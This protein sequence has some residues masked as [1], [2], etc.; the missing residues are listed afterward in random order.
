MV[1]SELKSTPKKPIWLMVNK[2][3][4]NA[5]GFHYHLRSHSHKWRPPTDVIETDQEIIVRVE[6]AGMRDSEFSISLNDRTLTIQGVRPD[7]DDRHAFHQMEIRYGEFLTEVALNWA[8][9]S[10]S[11]EADYSDGILK[12]IMPKAKPQKINIKK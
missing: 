11:V 9:D 5:G 8:V 6:I 4:Q 7:M 1:E 3:E 10:R 2:D 12:L